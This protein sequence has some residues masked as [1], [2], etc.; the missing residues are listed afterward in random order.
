MKKGKQHLEVL[1][2]LVSVIFFWLSDSLSCVQA[3]Y[4]LCTVY[5]AY[6]FPRHSFLHLRLHIILAHEC[7]VEHRRWKLLLFNLHS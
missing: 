2:A 5:T 6:V 3:P 1:L 4:W 7:P